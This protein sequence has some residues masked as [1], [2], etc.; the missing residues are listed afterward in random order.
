MKNK[1]RLFGKIPV[2]DILIVLVLAVAFSGAIW[3][4]TRNEV[5]EQTGADSQVEQTYPFTAVFM[6]KDT[7]AENVDL[8]QVGDELYLKGG[9][10]VGKVTAVRS[11][12][13]SEY[14]IDT[15]KEEQ[16]LS[17]FE[18]RRNI[19]L[20]VDGVATSDTEKGIFVLKKRIAFDSTVAIGNEKYYWTMRV[21]DVR[22]GAAQ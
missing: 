3:L 9:T 19:Y 1:Y 10:Y 8:V 11:E 16:V 12:P 2:V 6:V 17:T 13:Y 22:S 5:K 21:V 14:N 7:A 20:T 4:L 15:E 18:D